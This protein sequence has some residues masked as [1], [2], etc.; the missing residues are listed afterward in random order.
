[1]KIGLLTAPL[2]DLDRR[3]AFGRARELGFEAVELG[4]GEFTLDHHVGLEQLASDDAA[5]E[6]LRTDLS[7]A[8][9]ELSALSCH[10]NPLHPDSAYALRADRVL[11]NS[12]DVA[13]K[14]GLGSINLFSGCPGT[15]EGDDYPNW[16]TTPWPDY[17]SEL[18]EW[19][20]QERVIP[21][22]REINDLAATAKV[23]LAIEMHPGNV[24]YN[25][26]TLLRLRSAAGKQIGANF[27]PS[28]LWW[29]GIDPLVALREIA[30]DA[31]LV[32][33]HIKDTYLV[34]AVIART[35]VLTTIP[36]HAS[37]ERP[38]RFSTIG[39]GHGLDFWR[40][41]VNELRLVGYDGVLSVEHED[42][43]APID[44][45]L[46]RSVQLLHSCIWQQESGDLSWLEGHDP[47][48]PEADPPPGEPGGSTL[49]GGN[50]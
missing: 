34:P 38:W 43:F 49:G 41:F 10:G 7:D 35:G 36:S 27:D 25:P 50:S 26:A 8:A 15:P 14:L 4:S 18:L 12:I 13:S 19:Q 21:Y 39:Y 6:E 37:T 22:W 28:H 20:W 33:T 31:A 47:P 46:R 1:M 30:A 29:Q 24:V 3:A 32:N 40:A 48:V 23:K 42:P 2:G 11:R 16:V 5:V 45:A 44:E 17:F 9:L